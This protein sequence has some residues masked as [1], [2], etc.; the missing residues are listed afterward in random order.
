[1]KS[2]K[3]LYSKKYIK[4]AKVV[5]TN[6]PKIVKTNSKLDLNLL[7]L[8]LFK[9][10]IP[11]TLVIVGCLIIWT[12]VQGKVVYAIQSIV[13][14]DIFNK[15]AV[16]LVS[17]EY[18]ENLK[19]YISKPDANYFSTILDANKQ[20]INFEID[21]ESKNYTGAWKL[22]IPSININA[23]VQANVSPEES[24]YR[25]VLETERKLAHYKGNPIPGKPGNV[26]IYGHSIS[27]N[28]FRENSYDPVTEFTKLFD[29][30]TGD[31]IYIDRDGITYNYT[32]IKMKQVSPDDASVLQQDLTDQKILTLM[33]C[34]APAGDGSRRYI[35]IAKQDN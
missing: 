13:N 2:L 16:Q 21:D 11:W 1:M 17:D 19:K 7:S 10:F 30:N 23:N 20:L 26:F 6:S 5:N 8:I 31:K 22:R 12:E 29:L 3:K 9:N 24:I 28:Y 35:V 14:P 4:Q 18:I 34:G 32:V 27:K 25:K 33:T 15:E